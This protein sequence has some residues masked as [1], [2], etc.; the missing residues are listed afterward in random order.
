MTNSWPHPSSNATT[1]G[2]GSGAGSSSHPVASSVSATSA[3]ISRVRCIGKSSQ[4]CQRAEPFYEAW[5]LVEVV[6]LSFD[7]PH[8]SILRAVPIHGGARGQ[9]CCIVEF[10]RRIF[11][12]V[13]CAT[14]HGMAIC[15]AC[16]LEM[17]DSVGCTWRPSR[18][19]NGRSKCHDCG[20]PPRTLHHPGCDGERCRC[21]QM[22]SCGSG[23]A[24]DECEREDGHDYIDGSCRW[25]NEPSGQ[26]RVVGGA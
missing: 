12:S 11:V 14:L 16:D 4:N 13:L 26:L 15:M 20:A 19:P 18:I 17:L 22:L 21:G 6:K 25:C 24:V 7:M 1:T 9:G 10:D 3:E 2:V 5:P 8:L 23:C